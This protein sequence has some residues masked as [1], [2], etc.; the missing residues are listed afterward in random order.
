MALQ[1]DG[2]LVVA[3][4][5]NGNVAVMRLNADGSLDQNFAVGGRK[6]IDFGGFYDGANAV[7]LQPNGNIVL[8][9][10]GNGNQDFAV[11][12][13]NPDGSFDPTFD[14]DGIVGV[15]FGGKDVGWAVALQSNGKLV[16]AGATT[17]GS[18]QSMALMRL[19][20]D[21]ALD[22]T[23]DFD[24]K[25]TIAFGGSAIANAVA[26]QADGKIVL[27]GTDAGDVAVARVTGDR[28]TTV[29][30]GT[31]P[32]VVRATQSHRLWRRAGVHVS[33]GN[34]RIP[35]GTTFTITL[36]VPA[37]VRMSFTKLVPG[38][39]VG[40][41]CLPPT[42]RNRTRPACTRSIARGV[43]TFAANGGVNRRRFAGQLSAH[44]R[45]TPGR[46]A[47]KITPID[48]TGRPG[49]SVVLRFTIAA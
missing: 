39:R 19:N 43:L 33:P 6:T 2:R 41:A 1:R 44:R 8:A 45:L 48:P 40:R 42:G 34:R 7:L 32:S 29:A 17:T 12:R 31:R 3:G 9:G 25:K 5:A 21:G 15:N 22:T 28:P 37:T 11:V 49:T 26:L 36:N 18:V 20:A 46:Y 10:T 35:V 38:R 16:V 14:G 24:G 4:S 13:L 47:V 23:F 30:P 27:A